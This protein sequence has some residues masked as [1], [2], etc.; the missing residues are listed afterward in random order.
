MR[1]W[2]GQERGAGLTGL[3]PR[4]PFHPPPRIETLDMT[5][6]KP[7]RCDFWGEV[8]CLASI[9][10]GLWGTRSPR[11]TPHPLRR[12]SAYEARAP[13]NDGGQSPPLTCLFSGLSGREEAKPCPPLTGRDLLISSPCLEDGGAGRRGDSAGTGA[14]SG[15]VPGLRWQERR[16]GASGDGGG[17]QVPGMRCPCSAPAGTHTGSGRGNHSFPLHPQM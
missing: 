10:R 11:T 12:P 8:W 3:S 9:S 17:R 4:K 6:A 15:R 7:P 2:W 5:A 1:V 13:R 16:E 14:R